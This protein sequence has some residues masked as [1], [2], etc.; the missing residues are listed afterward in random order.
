MMTV[1]VCGKCG[2]TGIPKGDCDC[3]GNKLDCNKVCGGKGL[4]DECGVCNGPGK[5]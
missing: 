2:G 3:H 1:D 4:V 5:G